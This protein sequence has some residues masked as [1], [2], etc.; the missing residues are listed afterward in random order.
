[1][2]DF[3]TLPWRLCRCAEPEYPFD[4]PTANIC[5]PLRCIMGSGGTQPVNGSS[6]RLS[7][8]PVFILWPQVAVKAVH[9]L[10]RHFYNHDGWVR[11]RD[12]LCCQGKH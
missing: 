4:S 7:L 2:G 5:L 8:Y 11:D 12:G 1:M 3:R 10:L 6:V 9:R